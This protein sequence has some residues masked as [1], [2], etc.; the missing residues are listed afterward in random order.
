M[1]T[2]H[3]LDLPMLILHGRD[4]QLCNFEGSKHLHTEAKS[5]DKTLHIFD[6]AVHQLFLERPV[7]R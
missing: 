3:S 5:A 6:D 1:D 2:I 7:I 4:D